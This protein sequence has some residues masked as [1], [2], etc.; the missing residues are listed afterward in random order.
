MEF[1]KQDI[2]GDLNGVKMDILDWHLEIHV[3]FV[4]LLHIQF[5]RKNDL[6]YIFE[7]D[8]YIQLLYQNI[9]SKQ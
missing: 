1:G 7:Q 4:Q 3:V 9:Q 5:Y 8:I 2:N 6:Y